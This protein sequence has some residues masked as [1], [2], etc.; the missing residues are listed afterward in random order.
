MDNLLWEILQGSNVSNTKA[1]EQCTNMLGWTKIQK[2]E[3]SQESRKMAR[4]SGKK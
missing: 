3:K 1:F 2:A 4:K